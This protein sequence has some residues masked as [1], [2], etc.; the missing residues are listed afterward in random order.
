MQSVSAVPERFDGKISLNKL[1]NSFWL[2][3]VH[4]CLFIRNESIN[5]IPSPSVIEN[6][7]MYFKSRLTSHMVRKF[8]LQ[9]KQSMLFYF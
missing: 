4:S 7:S 2:R 1:H 5:C 6:F 9:R 8:N 3:N